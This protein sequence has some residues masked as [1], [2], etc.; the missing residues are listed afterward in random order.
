VGQTFLSASSFPDFMADRNVCPTEMAESRNS[1][2][3]LR[4]AIMNSTETPNA[5]PT[6]N[7]T[8]EP[9]VA[10]SDDQPIAIQDR[11]VVAM[12]LIVGFLL[13]ILVIV[14]LFVGFF[15]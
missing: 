4:G 10:D 5:V 13:G 2:F 14:D 7:P 1:N 3:S 11:L 8:V 15:R 12:F 9:G 6:A